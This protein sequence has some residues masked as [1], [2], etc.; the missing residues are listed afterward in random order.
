M[1]FN[2]VQLFAYIGNPN[3]VQLDL[4]ADLLRVLENLHVG[5]PA[6]C[7]FKRKGFASVDQFAQFAQQKFPGFECDGFWFAR[8]RP[9][10]KNE[11]LQC[12]AEILWRRWFCPRRCSRR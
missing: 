5:S 2:L 12:S 4:V 9:R 3:E 11:L 10:L 8:F 1:L 7:R 6:K